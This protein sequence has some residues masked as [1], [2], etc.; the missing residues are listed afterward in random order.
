MNYE[1]FTNVV[2]ETIFES[3]SSLLVDVVLNISVDRVRWKD[4]NCVNKLYAY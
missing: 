3:I 4:Y 2:Y 1:R